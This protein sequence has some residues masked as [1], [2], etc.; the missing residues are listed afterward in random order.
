M[1]RVSRAILLTCDIVADGTPRSCVVNSCGA[2]ADTCIIRDADIAGGKSPLGWTQ[3]NG[4]VDPEKV[5]A[6]FMGHGNNVPTNKGTSG[7]TGVEDDIP[8]NIL[9]SQRAQRREEHMNEMRGV[10][11]G[12]FNLPV[13]GVLGLGGKPTSYPTETIV[14]DMAGQGAEKGMPTSND[15]GE[16]SLIYRQVSSTVIIL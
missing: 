4:E 15:N 12:L 2:Q 6:A 3:G 16:V 10:F 1:R 7:A 13:I 5:V 14:G 11:S 8:A 9:N